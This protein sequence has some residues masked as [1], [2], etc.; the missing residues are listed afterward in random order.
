MTKHGDG[1]RLWYVSLIAAACLAICGVS[2]VRYLYYDVFP[3]PS[4]PV[5]QQ[6]LCFATTFFAAIYFAR[7]RLGHRGL[8]MVTLL[9]A[10]SAANANHNNAALFHVIVLAILLLGALIR[11]RY[12]LRATQHRLAAKSGSAGSP[13]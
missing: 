10:I 9:S 13:A 6:V 8:I 2:S 11:D 4:I 3:G 12:R 1:S 5:I 7:P